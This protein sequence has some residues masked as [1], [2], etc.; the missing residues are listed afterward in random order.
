IPNQLNS[1]SIQF[2][3]SNLFNYYFLD[4][5]AFPGFEFMQKFFKDYSSEDCLVVE[6]SKPGLVPSFQHLLVYS[7]YSA[8]I[9]TMC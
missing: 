7:Y 6:C 5:F 3:S 8:K 1:N 4:F 9:C 2:S